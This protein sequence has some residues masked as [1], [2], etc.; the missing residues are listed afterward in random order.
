MAS[1]VCSSD[2]SL[3]K[4]MDDFNFNQSDVHWTSFCVSHQLNYKT[5]VSLL[6]SNIIDLVAYF[7][8]KILDGNFSMLEKDKAFPFFVSSSF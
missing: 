8:Y 1:L 6:P 5:M 2:M 3:S 4:F 7:M